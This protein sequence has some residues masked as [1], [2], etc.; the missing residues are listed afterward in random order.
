[1]NECQEGV[2]AGLAK[3][4]SD[5]LLAGIT[6]AKGADVVYFANEFYGIDRIGNCNLLGVV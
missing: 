4:D 6:Q 5:H 2:G 3:L 1:M